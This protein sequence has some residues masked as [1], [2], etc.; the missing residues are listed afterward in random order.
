MRTAVL[1][2]LLLFTSMPGQAQ[3]AEDRQALV[4]QLRDAL[5]RAPS[6]EAAVMIEGRLRRMEMEA[7]TPAVT[8]LMSR[9]LRDLAAKSYDEAIDV[10]T[11]AITLDPNLAEAYH[12]RAIARFR[13]GDSSGAVRDIEETLRRE[14]RSF[15]AWRT[16]VDIAAA[17]ENW[18]SAY[19]ACEK[20]LEIN[21][22]MPGGQERLKD[23]KRRAF[24]QEA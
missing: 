24:G 16:L 12:Q 19:E 2:L 3:R 4:G 18:K 1:V 21:P 7:G 6:E 17:R 8:L 22:K 14:P 9:G 11:D 10:F 5:Q 13:G 23:L 15:A 20:L